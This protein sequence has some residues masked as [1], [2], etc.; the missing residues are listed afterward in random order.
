MEKRLLMLILLVLDYVSAQTIDEIFRRENGNEWAVE[1]AEWGYILS[2]AR[3]RPIEIRGEVNREEAIEIANRFLEKNAKYFGIESL[4]YTDSAQIRDF[5]GKKSWVIVYEGQKIEEF[6]VIDTHT[7]VIMTV[8]GQIYAVG[9]LRYYFEEQAIEEAHSISEEQ[10]IENAKNALNTNEK[11]MEIK[12]QIM[13]VI[14]DNIKPKIFWNVSFGC[15]LRKDVLVDSQGNVL[16][17]NE[18]NFKCHRNNKIILYFLLLFA[19]SIFFISF[20]K[21]GKKGIGFGLILVLA[22][23]TLVSLVMIQKEIYK[24][25]IK[26]FYLES[27]IDEINSLFESINLDLEKAI[28]I[29]AKRAIAIA[30]NEV[31]VSGRGLENADTAIKE[32]VLFG[33]MNGAKR[34]LME[35]VTLNNWL[36]KI[37]YV[38]LKKGYKINSSIVELNVK[39]YD[40]FNVLIEGYMWLNISDMSESVSIKR[41]IEIKKVISIENFEDPLYALNTN[42]RV[43]RVIKK[44]KFD[45]NYTQLLAECDGFGNWKYG[46]SFVSNNV[47]E[48]INAQNKSEKILVTE[49]INIVSP[50][51]VNQFLGV[52]SK[53]DSPN[54]VVDKVVNCSYLGNISNNANV[55]IDGKKGKVWYIDNLISQYLTGYYSPS[56]NGPSF[57]DR[58]EGKL[59]LQNKYQKMSQ[60]VIGLESFV[61]KDEF[62]RVEIE[63]FD[64]TNVDYLYFNRT[65]FSS[66]KVKGLP[67][68]F[69]IDNENSL[70][71][72]HQKY[73]GV[74]DLIE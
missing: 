26:K 15:P 53:N 49:N 58:L 12:K 70:L 23:L 22:A 41:K 27:R 28:D 73:Y 4:N 68:N 55:L 34:E 64:D 45:G 42:S 46:K 44:T 69:L 18:N 6:P 51:V 66:K 17:I 62:D 33:S 1:V 9:N 19:T 56:L 32:L 40:S 7:T 59:Y 14:D 3:P 61:N 54:V 31:I 10:A 30:V 11:P 71:D 65:F 5:E 67:K 74:I 24:K 21:K 25:N 29:T 48:I 13:P 72:N 35:N 39:P 60:K 20:L 50:N 8:D 47:N 57:L 2:A 63:V 43:T 36:E 38:G 52:V 16:G 37:S